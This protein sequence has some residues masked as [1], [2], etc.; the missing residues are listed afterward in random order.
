MWDRTVPHPGFSQ[1]FTKSYHLPAGGG[2]D[3]ESGGSPE[4]SEE[5][6]VKNGKFCP[7]SPI[8]DFLNAGAYNDFPER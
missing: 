7:V 5:K 1:N 6:S 2:E 8:L 4:E 3:R